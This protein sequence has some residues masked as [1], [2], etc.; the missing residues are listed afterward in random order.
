MIRISVDRFSVA[1]KPGFKATENLSTLILMM[2]V[3]RMMMTRT[4][5]K[6]RIRMIRRTTL[7]A[8][9]PRWVTREARLKYPNK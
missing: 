1:F 9:H 5:I 8:N 7:P 2:N 6:T 4:R 3:R